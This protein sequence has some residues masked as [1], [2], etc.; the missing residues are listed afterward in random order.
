MPH[1]PQLATSVM[2]LAQAV[3]HAIKGGGHAQ[4]PF[5][6]VC[7]LPQALP[8]EPQLLASTL[9]FTQKPLQGAAPTAH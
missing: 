5:A 1:A 7:V 6:Q 4:E 9:G 3:P 2:V 8:H